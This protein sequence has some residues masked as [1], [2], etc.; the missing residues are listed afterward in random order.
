MDNAGLEIYMSW[1]HVFVQDAPI[2]FSIPASAAIVESTLEFEWQVQEKEIPKHNEMVD[3]SVL[4]HWCWVSKTFTLSLYAKPSASW[5]FT[6]AQNG[7]ILVTEMIAKQSMERA[8][9]GV[10]SFILLI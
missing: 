6:D 10:D 9:D 7:I 1:I 3:A 2:I 4:A 8:R 5:Q